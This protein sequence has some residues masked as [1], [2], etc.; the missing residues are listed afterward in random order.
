MGTPL[1]DLLFGSSRGLGRGRQDF[2]L[3]SRVAPL[4]LRR[5]TADDVNPA[6]GH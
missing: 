6:F 3:L 1:R 4:V 5:S 2:I